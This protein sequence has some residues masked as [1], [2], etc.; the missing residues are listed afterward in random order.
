MIKLQKRPVALLE[1]LIAFALV[2]LCA[3][4][5][6]YPHIA[7]LKKEQEFVSMVE[8]DHVVNLLYVNRLQKLY[9]HE[10]PFSDLESN[11]EFPIDASLLQEIG[12]TKHF[13]FKGSYKFSKIKSKPPKQP[14]DAV[15][16][17]KLTFLFVHNTAKKYSLEKKTDQPVVQKY[18]YDVTIERTH[19]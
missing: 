7:I 9:Q 8:L 6:I 14:E 11:K 17:F 3:L 16:L 5:L 18:E 12:Y 2:A 19:K 10:I 4:P 1:V 15:Y 13:P